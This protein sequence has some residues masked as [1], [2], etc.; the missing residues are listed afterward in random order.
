M[1]TRPVIATAEKQD[2]NQHDRHEREGAE[3]LHPAGGA[4]VR[5]MVRRNGLHEMYFTRQSV[6][7]KYRMS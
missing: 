2:C 1:A 6:Y 4:A 5:R 7:V 3:H